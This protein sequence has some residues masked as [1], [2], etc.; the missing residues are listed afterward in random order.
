MQYSAL[1]SI[2]EYIRQ[3]YAETFKQ[4]KKAPSKTILPFT[5]DTWI[6]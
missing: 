2:F 3:A 1:D 6:T 4:K 5:D